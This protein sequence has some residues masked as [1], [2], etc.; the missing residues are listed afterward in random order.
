[1][2]ISKGDDLFDAVIVSL[3]LPGVITQVTFQAESAF[4]L[5][6]VAT[7]TTLQEC[8]DQFDDLMESHEHTRL[9]IDLISSSCLYSR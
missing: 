4:I 3:G 5:K 9:W 1:M 6:K 8:I 2:T 7:V